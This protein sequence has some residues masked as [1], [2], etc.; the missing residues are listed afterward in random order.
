MR[1]RIQFICSFSLKIII[2]NKNV[3]P[4]SKSLA[5][6]F[7]TEKNATDGA[8]VAWRNPK[9]NLNCYRELQK[10]VR[11]RQNWANCYVRRVT[12]CRFLCTA[13]H[14]R[15]RKWNRTI[16]Q[17]TIRRA[18]I[19]PKRETSR[20]KEKGKMR[21]KVLEDSRNDDEERTRE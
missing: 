9:A 15:R 2:L 5:S 14:F 7:S 21:E 3:R 20:W 10:I 16:Y 12:W 8:P 13:L 1:R 19:S 17:A 11:Q 6:T 4:I 18:S